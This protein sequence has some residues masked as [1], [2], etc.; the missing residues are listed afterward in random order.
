MA[1]S[2]PPGSTLSP[3]PYAAHSTAVHYLSACS[4]PPPQHSSL[5]NATPPRKRAHSP[6]CGRLPRCDL[7]KPSNSIPGKQPTNACESV[8]RILPSLLIKHTSPISPCV[9]RY[10]HSDGLQLLARNL[11]TP[12]S[13]CCSLEHSLPSI[14]TYRKIKKLNEEDNPVPLSQQSQP[15]Y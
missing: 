11:R 7:P 4:R 8:L 15:Y 9:K 2:W 14:N 6:A 1:S 3:M 10:L 13:I 12:T 5:H